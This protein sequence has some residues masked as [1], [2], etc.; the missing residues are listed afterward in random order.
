MK[1]NFLIKSSVAEFDN[2]FCFLDGI[3]DFLPALGD[4]FSKI[5]CELLSYNLVVILKI[6]NQTLDQA[7]SL[8]DGPSTIFFQSLLSHLE[9]RPNFCR[10]K[11]RNF[12]NMFLRIWI[13]VND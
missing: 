2:D 13:I 12:S 3:V 1:Y 9:L 7:L 6:L 4:R 10:T 11:K 5:G 8:F